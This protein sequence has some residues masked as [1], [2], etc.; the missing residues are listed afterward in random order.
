MKILKKE[1]VFVIILI[2]SVFA[3]YGKS[4]FFNFVELDED[5]LITNNINYI[6]DVKN[7]PKFFVT[8]C[9][10][11]D[12]YIYYR[13]ILNISFAIDAMILRDNPKIYHFTNIILFI[14]SIYFIYLFLS[15]LKLNRDI[16][17]WVCLLMAV[18]PIFISCVVWVPA[19]N[20]TLL[21]IFLMVSFINLI[22][23]L[24][25]NRLKYL[26][27]YLLFFTIALFTKETAIILIPVYILFIYTFNYKITKKQIIENILLFLPILVL[28]FVLR[29]ISVPSL[30]IGQ[31]LINWQEYS[32]NMIK[33]I[34]IYTD[35]FIMPEYIPIMLYKI[36]LSLKI[37]I[38]NISILLL[39]GFLFYKRIG[40]RKIILFGVVW[41][42][43]CLLPTFFTPEYLFLAH[44]LI[45]SSVGLVLIL[46]LIASNIITKYP[47]T[48][49]YLIVFASILFI[50]FSYSSYIQSD[51][52]ENS[53]VYWVNAYFDAPNYHAICAGLAKIYL[54]IGN[55]EKAKEL[56]QKALNYKFSY[57]YLIGSANVLFLDN[58]LD[59]AE[60]LYLEL[61]NDIQG[62]KEIIYRS[63]SELYFKK[64]DFVKATEYAQKAYYLIPHNI[65]YSKN[66][67]KMYELN[68]EYSKAI[69]LY[70]NLLEFDKN[71]D[72]YKNKINVLY[73]KLNN[74]ENIND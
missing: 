31:Y 52:Y 23:Y 11:S 43:L 5:I 55:V 45:I 34:M 28:Y 56:I 64:K 57:R 4:I 41:F 20:D 6:S 24:E 36:K 71:N 42:I 1:I 19:R 66:L 47:V 18:H 38:V 50:T 72:E 25:Q 48:K 8:S 2:L 70:K 30:G 74:K 59:K 14:L 29:N 33:G 35:K 46:S 53:N 51:K 39:L 62:S 73:T 15:K 21:V 22:N 16:L 40:N 13:P 61:L 32:V 7:V 58:D 67:A 10:Y 37:I 65:D 12:Q 26:I 63:L 69:E 54:R 49:K 17:K 9:Y 3:I 44:R 60:K 27:L 68:K